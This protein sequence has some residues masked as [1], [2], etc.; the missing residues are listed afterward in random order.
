MAVRFG[1]EDGNG[2]DF[3]PFPAFLS[4]AETTEWFQAWTGNGELDGREFRAFGQDG[5]GGYAAFWLI[6]GH[7]QAEVPGLVRAKTARADGRC[8]GN[9]GNV[10]GVGDHS[11]HVELGADQLPAGR[12]E[13]ERSS[14]GVSHNNQSRLPKVSSWNRSRSF[15][16]V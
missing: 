1:Y 5:T 3:E 10:L 13:A 12:I 11:G 4:A 6:R 9:P 16:S 7:L 2:V 15:T 8:G 14:S